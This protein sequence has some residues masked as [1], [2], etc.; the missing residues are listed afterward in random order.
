MFATAAK[1]VF[2]FLSSLKT[3]IPL[4]V[5]TIVVTIAI[6]LL[7]TTDLFKSWWYLGLLGLNGVSLL[8]ITILHIPMILERKGRNALIGVVATHLGILILI[9]GTIYGGMSGFRHKVHAIE[10]EITIVPGL[11]FAIHLEKM[12]VEEYPEGTFPEGSDQ[13]DLKKTQDSHISLLV[14]GQKQASFV[15]RPGVPARFE[16]TTILPSLNEIGWYFEL[17]ATDRHGRPKTIPVKP[18]ALPIFMVGDTQIMAHSRLAGNALSAEIFTMVDGQVTPLGVVGDNEGLSL[19]D[20][21]LS[22]GS[23]KRYTGL[24]I[25]NRPHGPL[26]IAGCLAMM[27]GL[28][29]HFYFRH[30]DRKTTARAAPRGDKKTRSDV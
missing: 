24:S 8:F 14:K 13:S 22:L 16:G 19:D 1:K 27:F 23:V 26:L 15:I 5:V 7:P 2:R 4:L 28:V 3:A 11:P 12:V 21:T 6:S 10:D 17:I 18:W 9:A 29:W 30:R 20:H 25:Y